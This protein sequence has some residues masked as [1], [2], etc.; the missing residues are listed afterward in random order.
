M[1]DQHPTLVRSGRSS[2]SGTPQLIHRLLWA[3]LLSCFLVVAG[4]FAAPVPDAEAVVICQSKK[5]PSKLK[6][7]R[8]SCGNKERLLQDL[9]LVAGPQ[10]DPGPAG[11]PGP[12]GV[13]SIFN[14]TNTTSQVYTGIDS[15]SVLLESPGV[16]IVEVETTGE[17]TDVLITFSAECTVRSTTNFTWLNLD[18]LF[19]G[20][21]QS[22]TNGDDA[23]CTSH[24]TDSLDTWVTA[25]FSLVVEDVPA[26]IHEIE[27]T[28]VLVATVGDGAANSWRID[29]TSLVVLTN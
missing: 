17:S 23:F 25:S 6:L 13:T 8:K 20:V 21:A 27:L 5:K 2:P 19:D 29:D 14:V 15:Q 10:G 1:I 9:S 28:G 7:R 18:L 3:T 24:A 26:G 22:P 11:P 12:A 16:T 4:S